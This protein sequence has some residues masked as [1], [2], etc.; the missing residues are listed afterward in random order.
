VILNNTITRNSAYDGGGIYEPAYANTIENTIVAGNSGSSGVDGGGDCYGTVPTDNAGAADKGGNIDGDG[1]C[2]LASVSHDL[3][4]TNPD[5]GALASNGGAV[6]TDALLAGSPAIGHAVNTPVACPTTDERGVTRPAACDVGAFQTS[7][8]DTS[9]SMSGPASSAFGAPVSYTLTI[10]NNGPAPATGVTVTDTLPA[11]T[12]YA[13]AGASQG[14][15]SGTTTI[16]CALGTL[17]STGSGPSNVATVTIVAFAGAAGTLTNTATVSVNETDPNHANNTATVTT[18]VAAAIGTGT[19]TGTGTTSTT[20]LGVSP[21]VLSTGAFHRTASSAK[22]NG[23][24]NTA[25][26]NTRYRFQFGKSKRYGKTSSSST[27]AAGSKQVRVVIKITRLK[28]R[29]TYHY[30]V[31]ATNATGT[32]YGKDMTFKTRKK[33]AKK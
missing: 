33:P 10:T 31:V 32:T 17:N 26:E 4:N 16:T 7:S 25:G 6:Q 30:R 14:S 20:L 21:V 5:L 12:T 9:I 11:G 27:L 3:I 19:G 8:A 13:S 23:M 29:T 24:V 2:F 22:L 18:T 1:T 28:A 15:C